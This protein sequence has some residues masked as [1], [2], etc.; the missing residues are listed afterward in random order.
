MI[1]L[2]T[3]LVAVS[4]ATAAAML[5]TSSAS[6][7]IVLADTDCSLS[8]GC[9]FNGNVTDEAPSVLELETAYNTQHVEPPL[10]ATIDLQGLFKTPGSLG[11]TSGTF[12]LP[13]GGL[14]D[15]IAIK[16]GNQFMLYQVSPT[17]S[18]DWTTAGLVNNR[19]IPHEASHIVAF[20]S[21]GAVPEA[22][23]WAM[24]ILGFAGVGFLAYRRKGQGRVR[25]A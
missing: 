6:A 13:G 20:S 17:N 24:M 4:I 19:G 2:R 5:S 8:S 25:V 21:V 9:L 18:V 15:F 22:S 16:A 11:G 14:F 23:T 1:N 12:T 3:T 10:P 7:A